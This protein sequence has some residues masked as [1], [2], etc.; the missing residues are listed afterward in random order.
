MHRSS[1]WPC[2]PRLELKTQRHGERQPRRASARVSANCL[3]QKV[4]ESSGLGD[5]LGAVLGKRRQPS[6]L[7]TCCG[8]ARAVSWTAV[9]RTSVAPQLPVAARPLVAPGAPVRVASTRGT[10]RSVRRGEGDPMRDRVAGTLGRCA[11]SV[12]LVAVSVLATG[13]GLLGSTQPAGAGTPLTAP[14]APTEVIAFA[15]ALSAGVDWRIPS[16]DGGT[17]ITKYTIREPT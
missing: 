13:A 1:A 12:F 11:L 4:A 3:V 17:P 5:G 7:S 8:A 6:N 16:S 10:M 9:N 14:G 15:G 2:G